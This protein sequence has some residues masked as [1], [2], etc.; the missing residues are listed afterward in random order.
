MDEDLGERDETFTYY[1]KRSLSE[2]W[3]NFAHWENGK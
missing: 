1:W 2:R 3:R